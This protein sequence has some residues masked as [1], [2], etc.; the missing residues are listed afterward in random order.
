LH[1]WSLCT[2]PVDYSQSTLG[3]PSCG[4]GSIRAHGFCGMRTALRSP[5]FRGQ[6]RDLL[7]SIRTSRG[8]REPNDPIPSLVA[9]LTLPPR[10]RLLSER[11]PHHQNAQ[12]RLFRCARARSRINSSLREMLCNNAVAKSRNYRANSRVSEDKNMNNVNYLVRGGE[13]GIRTTNLACRTHLKNQT[14]SAC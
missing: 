11:R 9:R 5:L 2:I 6:P 1:H 14:N 12:A 13:S 10:I 8:T 4:E 7:R 3:R